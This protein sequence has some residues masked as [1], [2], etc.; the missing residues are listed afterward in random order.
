MKI[1]E[2]NFEHC[3]GIKKLTR[4][5]NF[6]EKKVFAIY[7]SNGSMKTSFAKTFMDLSK[8]E[9]SKDAIYTDKKTTRKITKDGSNLSS[10][11]VFVTK[12]Y[13]QDYE[14][15]EPT[16]RLLVNAELKK[17]YDRQNAEIKE[18]KNNFLEKI[19][20]I[21]GLNPEEIEAEI[22]SA[23]YHGESGKFF[24]SLGRIEKEI[25]DE[26]PIY[27]KIK[28]SEL[29]NEKTEN[30]IF[31][32]EDKKSTFLENIEKYVDV[33]N[34]L[35]EQSRFFKKGIFNHTQASVVA[36]QLEKNGFFK[37]EHTIALNGKN[38]RITT[39]TELGQVI[40]SEKAKIL[41]DALL[42][43]QFDPID[44]ILKRNKDLKQFREYLSNNTHIIAEFKNIESFKAKLL[45]DYLKIE[46][47]NFKELLRKFESS[48]GIIKKTKEQAANEKSVWY[49]VIEQFNRRFFVPF[50][51][52][53]AN[54]TNVVLEE[55]FPELHFR[56]EE[57]PVQKDKLLEVLS[58]GEKRALYIL[59]ILFEI[60][61]RKKSGHD[62]V[63]ILDDI[64]DSFDYKNKYAIIEYLQDISQISNFYLMILTHNFDFYRSICSRLDMSRKHKLTATKNSTGI[65]LVS[66]HYHNNP[67]TSW[68]NH[69]DTYNNLLASIPMIRNLFQ[70]AGKSDEFNRMTQFL[71]LKEDTKILSITDLKQYYRKILGDEQ[72]N[73]INDTNKKFYDVLIEECNNIKIKDEKLE[74]KIILSIAIRL[75]AEDFMITKLGDDY[76]LKNIQKNQTFELFK[77]YKETHGQDTQL[78]NDEALKIL[79]K[80]NLMTPENIHLNSFM[81]EPILDM[82]IDEL[83]TLYTEVEKLLSTPQT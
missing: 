31:N 32:K 19:Q 80:V 34:Q 16:S 82:G 26:D 63:L 38:E 20:E 14:T 10:N 13:D 2:I 12:P 28:F 77:E 39:K 36:D 24:E 55:E 41:E 4:K 83:K 30:N 29:F 22:C 8:G 44:N 81:Y 56:F 50:K 51:L 66:E 15:E 60:E 73:K 45:K 76:C 21:S 35:L 11:E 53:V 48:K 71:H 1:L 74:S 37:A 58:Q 40:E 69:L 52:E 67:L 54:V 64:A 27:R 9:H 43:E 49:R 23:F 65:T 70:Y 79:G 61:V 72:T 6:S 68:I 47:D 33:Y 18:A 17:K 46:K 3:Y 59:N 75:L 62:C 7:A 5:F 78:R 25:L 57:K 42:K